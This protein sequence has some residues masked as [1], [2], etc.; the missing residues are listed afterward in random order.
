MAKI[1]VIDDQD[2]IRH[3]ISKAIESEG[4]IVSSAPS[5]ERGL[6]AMAAD[7][8]DAVILDLKLP[9]MNGMEVLKKNL[10]MARTFEP[11]PPDRMGRMCEALEPF[12]SGVSS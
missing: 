2:T 12:M 10:N 3:F 1:L 6:E 5:G 11:L 7:P 9:G 4:H 8:P